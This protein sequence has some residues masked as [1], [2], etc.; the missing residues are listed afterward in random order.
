MTDATHSQEIEEKERP[1][2]SLAQFLDTFLG[3]LRGKGSGN[4]LPTLEKILRQVDAIGG[5]LAA[6][7]MAVSALRRQILPTL[8]DD[9]QTIIR[10]EDL[11]HQAR[12]MIGESARR[13]RVY[14]A[15]V[16]RQRTERLRKISHGL[17]TRTSIPELMNVLA[18]ELPRLGISSCY[19][20]L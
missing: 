20:G 7:Q 4:F 17:A 14:E 11:W 1:P 8:I 16:V 10:A 3:E 19:L 12:I 15:W 2:E 13:A 9:P 5:D 6:W 18:E